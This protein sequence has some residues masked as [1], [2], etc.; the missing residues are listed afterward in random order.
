MNVKKA[1]L[2]VSFGTSHADTRKKTIDKMEQNIR[3]AFPGYHIH[4][5][6]TSERIRKILQKRDSITVPNVEEALTALLKQGYDEVIIQP[7]V[8]ITGEEYHEKIVYVAKRFE[9]KFRKLTTGRPLL[10]VTGDYKKVIEV[11][12]NDKP[13]L[14]ADQALIYMGHGTHHPADAS[15]GLLQLMFNKTFP[16]AYMGTICGYPTINEVI[17]ELKEK[18]IKKALLTPFLIVAGEHAKHDMAGKQETSWKSLLE[19]EGI[20]VDISM[21]GL[22]ESAGIRKIFVNNIIDSINDNPMGYVQSNN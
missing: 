21:V 11:L 18:G 16:G 2:A 22:G 9:K 13:A 1:I 17:S 20:E 19:K 7:L 15:Y 12:R 3:E 6:F 10:T 14:K 8:I 5:A 4:R